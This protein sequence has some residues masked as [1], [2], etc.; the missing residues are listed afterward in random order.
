MPDDVA[1]NKAAT[2]ERC[3]RRVREET[4]ADPAP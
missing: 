1:L 3:L 4:A 2:I